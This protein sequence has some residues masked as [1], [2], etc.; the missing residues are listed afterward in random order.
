MT[1]ALATPGNEVRGFTSG[2]AALAALQGWPPDLIVADILMPEMDGLA[3]A[4]LV[5]AC[6]GP[7]VLIVSIAARHADAVLAGAIG[8]VKKPAT[9][10]EVR[11][12]VTEVLGEGARR[13]VILVVDDDDDVREIFRTCLEPRFAVVEAVNGVAALEVLRAHRVDLMI[14]DVHMP[15]MNGVELLRAV[16]A[17][18]A[19]ERLPVIVQTSDLTALAAPVWYGLDVAHR[20]D[21]QHF[22]TWIRGL[23]EARI[24]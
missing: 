3:F 15:L 14:T 11:R 4:R 16:R 5:R 21:K 8:L 6:G 12:A 23:V 18:P 2:R 13:S 24:G 17:D 9:A 10:A 20:I 22:V 7:P 19:L 1:A